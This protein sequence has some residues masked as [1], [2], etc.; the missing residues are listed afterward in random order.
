MTSTILWPHNLVAQ[1]TSN[2]YW[3][4]TTANVTTLWKSSV[5]LHNCVIL[6]YFVTSGIFKVRLFSC[7][8]FFITIANLSSCVLTSLLG[9]LFS[10]ATHRED[11]SLFSPFQVDELDMHCKFISYA[12]DNSLKLTLSVYAFSFAYELSLT[13]T[14]P[15]VFKSYRKSHSNHLI[16]ILLL[17]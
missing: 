10:S 13:H 17:E 8:E 16:M 12:I 14:V 4:S 6:F 7:L 5:S 2:W 3:A 9:A 1:R 15:L 11:F